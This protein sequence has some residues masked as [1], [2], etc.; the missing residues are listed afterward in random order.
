MY[1]IDTDSEELSNSN[2][3]VEQEG[4][5]KETVLVL[6]DFDMERMSPHELSDF[7]ENAMQDVADLT[8]T[9]AMIAESI[10][11]Q[12]AAAMKASLEKA[13]V[14]RRRISKNYGSTGCKLVAVESIRSARVSVFAL[15]EEAEEEVGFIRRILRA[16]GNAFKWLWEKLTGLFSSSDKKGKD[17]EKKAEVTAETLEKEKNSEIPEPSSSGKKV[18]LEGLNENIIAW[19][20]KDHSASVLIRKISELD[21]LIA[22][23]VDEVPKLIH[24]GDDLKTVISK[25]SSGGED[26]MA[27][28][29]KLNEKVTAIVSRWPEVNR[30]DV[31]KDIKSMGEG[32]KVTRING[33]TNLP[34]NRGFIAALVQKNEET[35]VSWD[36]FPT[37]KSES[38]KVDVTFPRLTVDE[39]TQMIIAASKL[40]QTTKKSSEKTE[41]LLQLEKTISPVI[42]S[43]IKE[44]FSGDGEQL[45]AI[46]SVITTSLSPFLK[47][48]RNLSIF[49]AH[50]PLEGEKVSEFAF[51]YINVC[52]DDRKKEKNENPD[53]V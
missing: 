49:Y 7:V 37:G 17:L 12:D 23:F 15:E 45:K 31:E 28:Y 39:S 19:I 50:M 35:P 36:V 41:Q 40:L 6:Q 30:S 46:R 18:E 34:S 42:E 29:V 16:I 9:H 24:F 1:E 27:A 14:L 51:R 13:R 32:A 47:I 3:G 4:F 33:F 48:I 22:S 52:Q 26:G 2:L 8:E 11:S 38:E 44:N 21:K 20:G 43:M 25:V 10:L 5:E 53:N